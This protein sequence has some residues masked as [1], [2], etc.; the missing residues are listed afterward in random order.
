MLTLLQYVL[1]QPEYLGSPSSAN[2]SG[3]SYWRCPV[4]LEDTFHTFPHKPPHRDRAKCWNSECNFSGDLADMLK[5]F[6][7]E[8][9]WGDRKE[10]IRQLE[11]EWKG[12][13]GEEWRQAFPGARS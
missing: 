3:V 4:C 10:R 6:H 1:S 5:E 9:N 8:E 7:P 12:E 2:V 11:I 13:Q